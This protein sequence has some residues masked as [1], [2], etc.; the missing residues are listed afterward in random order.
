MAKYRKKPVVVEAEVYKPGMEDGLTPFGEFIFRNV[1]LAAI[2]AKEEVKG[3]PYINTKQGEIHV[4]KG[5]YI[6]TQEDGER[7][8]CN[9]IN[10]EATYEPVEEMEG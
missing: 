3:V 9:P 1:H 6:I 10:F 7:Y 2:W 4:K 8:P 5:D